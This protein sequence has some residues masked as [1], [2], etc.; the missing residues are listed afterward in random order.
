[1]GGIWLVMRFCVQVGGRF[2]NEE[3][4]GD[5]CM[6]EAGGA[7]IGYCLIGSFFPVTLASPH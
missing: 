5:G 6:M 7:L 1:M 3:R 2:R 4:R